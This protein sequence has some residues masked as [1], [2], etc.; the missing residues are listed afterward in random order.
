M[1]E[2][3]NN[4]NEKNQNNKVI[5][6]KSKVFSD[7]LSISSN[8]EELFT[9]LYPIGHG[10]FGI[11]YK[12]IHNSTNSIVAIKIIDLFKNIKN[13][14]QIENPNISF[15]YYSVQQETF[16]MKLVN[17]SKYIV[18]YYGSYFSRNTNTL[19]LILEYCSSG[20]T[21]DLMLAM[22]RTFTEIEIATIIE[23]ILQGLIIIHS[24][25]LIHRDIKGANILLSEQGYAKLGDFGVGIQ[26]TADA[27]HRNSKKGSP[28]WM[29]PQV[30][31]NNNYDMKTDIWSLGITCVELCNG[32]PPFANLNPKNVME[33]IALFPPS[34][35]EVIN[36]NEHTEDFY[37]FIK[38]CL[39][40]EP[41]K[42]PTAKELIKHKFIT[43]YSKGNKFLADLVSKHSDDIDKYRRRI[44]KETNN[45]HYIKYINEMNNKIKKNDDDNHKDKINENS[46][47]ILYN[48]I[49][50]KN[51]F[52]IDN[53]NLLN[54]VSQQSIN[55]ESNITSHFHNEKKINEIQEKEQLLLRNK[56]ILSS[57]DLENCGI[58]STKD[59]QKLLK[60]IENI[61]NDSNKIIYI[62][63]N[64]NNIKSDS[65]S[66]NNKQMYA[67]F[68]N[69]ENEK[70]NNNEKDIKERYENHRQCISF[71]KSNYCLKRNNIYFKKDK[72]NDINIRLI[73]NNNVY[74]KPFLNRKQTFPI[75][76][77]Q[78]NSVHQ[79]INNNKKKNNK[80]ILNKSIDYILTN[81]TK[82]SDIQKN[83]L[84][85]KN[86]INKYVYLKPKIKN[87]SKKNNINKDS[88]FFN[89]KI[90]YNNKSSILDIKKENEYVFFK[91]IDEEGSINKT[92][93]FGVKSNFALFKNNEVKNVFEN[94]NYYFYK[95]RKKLNEIEDESN[96]Y[97]SQ[98][99]NLNN[100]YS[101]LNEKKINQIKYHINNSKKMNKM[102]YKY[103]E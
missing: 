31:K 7:I 63:Y 69:D 19:W 52:M 67:T 55:N 72:N 53:N 41:K 2:F 3:I 50:E 81:N 18:N 65:P 26:L 43:K 83:N 78:N 70:D 85:D 17:E 88:K 80:H 6:E 12:A 35:D 15:N 77:K 101:D 71:D 16:L 91:N 84:N 90:Y 9:I 37:D 45:N 46:N 99:T 56:I 92:N 47:N 102:H 75:E 13:K 40:I 62:S 64:S 34:V 32:E 44:I 96:G 33:K 29:S 48:N 60:N 97:K 95:N 93:L 24:M 4:Q 54:K 58:N 66:K 39:E 30:V 10:G 89:H 68:Y 42:R 73:K 11:V 20:S 59:S 49:N 61:K 76:K 1:N 87:N 21:I 38:K 36:K 23:N 100:N 28:Y 14:S 79:K 57:S 22:N 94:T 8:P 25:N 103:F 82:L 5:S 27:D 51:K 74:N 98:R 86:K